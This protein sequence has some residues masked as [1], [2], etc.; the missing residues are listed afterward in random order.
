MM[1]ASTTEPLRPHS[2]YSYPRSVTSYQRNDNWLSVPGVCTSLAPNSEV[3]SEEGEA[4]YL[5]KVVSGAVRTFKLL[6]DGRRQIEAFYLAG[7][8]FGIEAGNEHCFSADTICDS[9][10]QLINR[11]TLEN[12]SSRD[13]CVAQALWKITALQLNR[14]QNHMLLLGRKSAQERLATFLLQMAV[15]IPTKEADGVIELPMSRQDIADYLGLTAE[16]VS[17]VFAHY[18]TIDVINLL[19]SRRIELRNHAM[20]RKLASDN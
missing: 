13:K 9:K 17:R 4:S 12:L 3:Y 18:E 2:W 1:H 5:Y 10:I 14:A 6:S 19:S 20:L 7:D 8:F 15:R 11:N 16:T